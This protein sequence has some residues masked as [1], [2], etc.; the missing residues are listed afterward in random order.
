MARLFGATH[1]QDD[2]EKCP[3]RHAGEILP[4]SRRHHSNPMARVLRQKIRPQLLR[5]QTA[6]EGKRTLNLAQIEFTFLP[7]ISTSI[8][9]IITI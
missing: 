8:K 1:L 4:F 5:T 3:L 6:F 2:G 9:H 7:L